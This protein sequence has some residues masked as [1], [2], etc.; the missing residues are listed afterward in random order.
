MMSPFRRQPRSDAG[1]GPAVVLTDDHLVY[2]RAS[3]ARTELDL[4]DLTRV[5]VF[6]DASGQCFWHIE[7]KGCTEAIVPVD[8][9]G[10][11]LI[12]QYLS[13]WRGFDYDGLVRFVSEAQPQG[14]RQLWPLTVSTER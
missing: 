9:P 10:E 2:Q 3:G 13:Q 4:A 12:R 6:A 1:S 14:R 11:S 8:I 5:S 7:G